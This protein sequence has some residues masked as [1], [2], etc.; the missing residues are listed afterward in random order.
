MELHEREFFIARIGTGYYKIKVSPDVVIYVHPL[1]RD[2]IFEAAEI[3]QEALMEALDTGVMS[4][5]KKC[6]KQEFGVQK[7]K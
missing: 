6:W 1:P 3:F 7:K 5:M 4:L 2:E